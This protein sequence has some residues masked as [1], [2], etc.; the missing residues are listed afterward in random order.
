MAISQT[1]TYFLQK[2]CVCGIF[3]VP[4]HP[5]LDFVIRTRMDWSKMKHRWM[6]LALSM[7]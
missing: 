7:K 6:G 4:L 2:S 5:I 3:F 1:G